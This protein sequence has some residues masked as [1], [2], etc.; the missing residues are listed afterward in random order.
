MATIMSPPDIPA[1]GADTETRTLEVMPVTVMIG[2]PIPIRDVPDTLYKDDPIGK[3][4][5]P[6]AELNVILEEVDELTTPKV[7]TS[8]E[9]LKEVIVDVP[10]LAELSLGL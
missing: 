1:G 2:L 8:E 7:Y 10:V 5:P 3:G 6:I 9:P 4:M